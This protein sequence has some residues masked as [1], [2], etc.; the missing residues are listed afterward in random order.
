MTSQDNHTRTSGSGESKGMRIMGKINRRT[1]IMA[2]AGGLAMTGTIAAA[3][4]AA[5]A[6]AAPSAAAEANRCSINVGAIAANGTS[7]GRFLVATTPPSETGNE[8]YAP[9]Y[10]AGKIP[11]LSSSETSYVGVSSIDRHGFVII[12][13]QL[14]DWYHSSL[15]DGSHPTSSLKAIGGGWSG[16]RAVEFSDWDLR[17]N[18]SKPNAWHA[19][20]YGLNGDGTLSRWRLGAGYTFGS[21]QTFA[22]F[23]SVK[24]MTLISQTST[25]DTLLMNTRGGALYTVR[26][27]ITSP[28]KP[29]VKIVRSS[30]WTSFETLLAR[31]CGQYGTLLAGVDTDTGSA[32]LYAVGHANGTSTVIQSLGKTPQ[33]V[34]GSA[35]HE[36]TIDAFYDIP[37]FGE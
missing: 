13:D 34:T 32:Q 17:L 33:P 36:L 8:T 9:A 10:W 11:R 4:P 31:R 25:Y 30:G 26:I 7:E 5:S 3:A 1:R 22:G 29:I 12:G 21:K 35:L 15:Y 24:S 2:W 27:P 18:W 37:H 20:F 23:S 19:H 14:R 6:A 28:M 16:V